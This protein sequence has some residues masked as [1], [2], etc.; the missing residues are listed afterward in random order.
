MITGTCRRRVR[1]ALL[2]MMAMLLLSVSAAQA[3]IPQLR[4]E[5]EANPGSVIAW[6]ALGN[7]YYQAAQFDQAKNS[8]LEAIALD[9][10]SGDAH[11]GLGLSE[12]SRGDFQAALFEFTEVTRLHSERFDG[13]FNRAVTLAR[14][15]RSQESAT[16]FQTALE[17]AAPEATDADRVQAHLG[18]AGQLELAG[19]YSGAAGAYA[20]ALEIEPEN[21]SYILR[22]GQALLN[23]GNGLEAL[24]ELTALESR[25]G[26]YRVSALIADIYVGQGQI[27]YAM[28]SLE[29][30][31]EKAQAASDG[32]A[33]A[34]TLVKLGTLQRS[35]GRE[36]D[37]AASYESAAQVD[38]R[39]WEAQYNLGVT[40]L[41]NGQT[42]QALEPLQRAAEL[43]PD[44]SDIALA[45]A[46]A[47]DQ[48]AQS[49]EALAYARQALAA[50]LSDQEQATNAQFI[51]G[52]AQYRLGDFRAASDLLR[53]VLQSR[54]TDPLS[55]MW[56]GLAA[57]QLADYTTA[58]GNFERAVQLNPNNV[59]ARA[60]L[61]AGYL[62][63]QRYQ[64]AETVYSLLVS[65]NDSDFES[66]YNLGWALFSQN[67]RS[68]ATDAWVS[69]CE[70][71]YQPACS[72]IST[73]L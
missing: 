24:P 67:R 73:Y 70:L 44:R 49:Q 22:R 39:S 9:Y 12:F 71:G 36:S 66:L 29:R 65:Q 8:F 23:A 46:T 33:Q 10:T 11:Y 54:P 63:A 55:Q 30:A 6:V 17:Q 1:G 3:G 50:G 72:A 26:D 28:W 53:L 5:V 42:R 69:S 61:G 60:N 2:A 13:H 35:L 19:D 68:A 14:L 18:L 16:S 59:E 43:A 58:V 31:L 45:L 27:D 51:A 15:R 4:A 57:Y 34:S 52:R 64:E 37:A 7:A 20:D 38:P 25:S 56:A 21:A 32:A 40:Y 48:L 62:A 47:H 41:E